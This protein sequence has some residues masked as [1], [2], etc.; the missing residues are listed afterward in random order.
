MRRK[1]SDK[2]AKY[3]IFDSGS[4]INIT[5]NCLVSMFRDLGTA[6]QGEFLVTPAVIYETTE[7]PMKIKRFEWGAIRIQNLIDEE[8]IRPF[9][10]EEICSYK[11]LKTKTQ[12]VLNLVNN[13]LFSEGK[14]VHLIEAGEAECLALSIILAKKGIESAVV[15]DERT[16]RMVCEN[17]ENLREIMESKLETKIEMKKENFKIFQDIKVLRSTEMVYMAFK[18]GIIDTDK[19]KLE[20][21]LYALKFGGCSVSEKEIEFMK[22]A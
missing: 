5:Q 21:M 20:A 15:I 7:H 13:A 22:K 4:I 12:E 16:A 18:K 8:L 6:F 19:K 2:M 3:L 10:D 11:D 1:F 9:Q 14:A 17:P